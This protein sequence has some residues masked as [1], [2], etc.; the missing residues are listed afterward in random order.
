ML[1]NFFFPFSTKNNINTNYKE[2]EPLGE[3]AMIACV[4]FEGAESFCQSM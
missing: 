1:G 2:E 3:A 4:G